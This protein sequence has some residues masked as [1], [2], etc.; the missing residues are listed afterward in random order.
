MRIVSCRATANARG[1]LGLDEVDFRRL[2]AVVALVGPNGSGKTRI[3]RLVR[4]GMEQTH[5]WLENVSAA[6]A[7]QPL[8]AV[9]FG[10]RAYSVQPTTHLNSTDLEA[11]AEQAMQASKHGALHELGPAYVQRVVERYAWAFSPGGEV[12]GK[13]AAVLAFEGLAKLFDDLLGLELGLDRHERKATLGGFPLGTRPMSEGQAAL[14]QLGVILHAQQAELGDLVLFWDEPEA[15]LHP[16]AIVDVFE[17]IQRV[18]A[19]GQIWLATHS[20]ALVAHLE[21]DALWYV[22]KGKA[23]WAGR[24]PEKVISGLFGGD[25]GPQKLATFLGLPAQFGAVRFAMECLFEP[26]VL[27]ATDSDEQCR[28]VRKCLPPRDS[29]RPLRMLDFGAGKGRFLGTLAAMQGHE[30]V[31]ENI[32][33]VAFDES[34]EHREERRERIREVW[35]EEVDRRDVD[36]AGTAN[37]DAVL[38]CNVLHEIAPEKWCDTFGPN[39]LIKQ[40]LRSDG[41]LV[42]VEDYQLPRGEKAHQS[43]FLLLAGQELQTLFSAGKL[44]SAQ[45]GSGRLAAHVIPAAHVGNVTPASCRAAIELVRSNATARVRQ[46]RNSR[47]TSYRQGLLHALAT[48]LVVN[49]ILALESLR[50]QVHPEAG[51]PSGSSATP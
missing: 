6:P 5:E 41:G 35:P 26:G 2:G 18:N 4:E 38:L 7:G 9:N 15:H 43:G 37:V 17:R 39:G 20:D 31:R 46:I 33:Y 45:S 11:R 8:R 24:E 14:L 22:E 32:D 3:L 16:A 21:P 50:K 28:L 30:W 48:Q 29:E 13:P 23:T 10:P 49:S 27:G 12:P 47:D 44:T 34:P 19:G 42:V 51:T 36:R 25:E 40:V 1:A